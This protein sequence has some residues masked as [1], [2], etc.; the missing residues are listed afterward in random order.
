MNLYQCRYI[1]A[2]SFRLYCNDYSNAA[3]VDNDDYDDDDLF[4][5]SSF[6]HCNS[7]GF[8]TA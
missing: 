4:D 3:A 1:N 8:V 2:L 6:E 7:L 5:C